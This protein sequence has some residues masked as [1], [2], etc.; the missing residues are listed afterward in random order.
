MRR[1]SLIVLAFLLVFA[2]VEPAAHGQASGRTFLPAAFKADDGGAGGP[3]IA[4]A[5]LTD[6]GFDPARF[7]LAPNEP[8]AIRNLRNRPAT[9]TIT[10]PSA[11]VTAGTSQQPLGTGQVIVNVAGVKISQPVAF[12]GG[13]LRNQSGIPLNF[14]LIYGGSNSI[15]LSGG[16]E[17]YGVIYAPNAP[18][19]LSGGGHWFG[20]MTVKTLDNSGGSPL[21]YDR[22][23]IVPPA[24][25]GPPHTGGVHGMSGIRR[26]I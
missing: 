25:Y 17:A 2:P 10:D 11:L 24:A 22:A 4:T 26:T 9:L 3:A 6:A 13:A 12:S 5:D 19:K 15:V 14:Q 18:V 1:A 23:L 21:H 20:A 8:I 7:V 16:T